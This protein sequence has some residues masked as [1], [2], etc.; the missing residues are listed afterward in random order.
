VADTIVSAHP[1]GVE[2]HA[3]DQLIWA[4]IVLMYHHPDQ[5]RRRWGVVGRKVCPHHKSDQPWSEPHGCDLRL[6]ALGTFFHHASAAY[7]RDAVR[8]GFITAPEASR[9]VQTRPPR[10]HRK[11]LRR[12]AGPSPTRSRRAAQAAPVRGVV[13]A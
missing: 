6:Q 10:R 12:N 11:S 13:P 3:S 1:P 4:R 7:V 8:A 5:V 2:S 9:R